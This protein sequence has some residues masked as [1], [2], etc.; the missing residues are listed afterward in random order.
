MPVHTVYDAV[1]AAYF[2]F[3]HISKDL[4]SHLENDENDYFDTN[5]SERNVFHFDIEYS[6]EW[7][8]TNLYRMVAAVCV[9]FGCRECVH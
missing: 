9:W 4:D 1:F 8:E 3:K 6:V 2:A 7:F 5:K